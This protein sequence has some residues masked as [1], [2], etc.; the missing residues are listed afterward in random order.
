MIITTVDELIEINRRIAELENAG[1]SKGLS[2]VIADELAF[3]RADG[4]IINKETFLNA[5]KAGGDRKYESTESVDV[6]NN[7]AIIRCII[8]RNKGKEKVHNIRLF[9]KKDSNWQ[10]LGWANEVICS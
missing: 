1:D 6:F 7:R 2:A 5:L 9:V 4:S 8:S 10:L 3:L